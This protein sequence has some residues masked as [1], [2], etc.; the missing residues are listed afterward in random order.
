[1]LKECNDVVDAWKKFRT[2]EAKP[3]NNSK[4]TSR[5]DCLMKVINRMEKL[6][7][8]MCPCK[9]ACKETTYSIEKE[10]K[11][12]RAGNEWVVDLYQ[13]ETVTEENLV[14]DFPP[15]RFLGTFGGVLGLA[16]KFQVV[17]QVFAFIILC[18]CKLLRR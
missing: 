15:E 11:E 2:S 13:E 10:F 3:F 9:S 17:F 4:Y 12:K 5:R 6:A 16:G 8:Y 7:S 18:V 14:R 1:M